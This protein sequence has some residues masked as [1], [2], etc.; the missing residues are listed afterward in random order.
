MKTLLL[1][2][3]SSVLLHKVI[4]GN[5]D[6][7]IIG[8][9]QN[10]QNPRLVHV[11]TGETRFELLG[12]DTLGMV[13]YYLLGPEKDS[14]NVGMAKYEHRFSIAFPTEN[15]LQVNYVNPPQGY[16]GDLFWEFKRVGN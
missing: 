5:N 15:R 16:T 4:P 10:T 3:L 14:M 11:Y 6:K 9:W 1:V 13:N 12:T 7:L 2:V 8:K